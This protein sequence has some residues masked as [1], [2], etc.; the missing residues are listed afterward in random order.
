MSGTVI[1]AIISTPLA[2]HALNDNLSLVFNMSI[3]L[4]TIPTHLSI[5]FTGGLPNELKCLV[6]ESV[7]TYNRIRPHLSLNMKTQ[8]EV[9]KKATSKVEVA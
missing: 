6:K 7:E 4:F 2:R 9:H 5:F 3:D 1:L 8:E